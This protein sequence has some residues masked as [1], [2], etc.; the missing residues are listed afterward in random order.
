[1]ASAY[2]PIPSSSFF[3]QQALRRHCR[4]ET[5]IAF[6][7]VSICVADNLCIVAPP[8]DGHVCHPSVNEVRAFF[9]VRLDQYTIGSLALAAMVGDRIAVLE[10]RVIFEMELHQPA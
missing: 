1:M 4:D 7:I 3:V 2:L 6:D 9:G 8:R 5:Q 10:M